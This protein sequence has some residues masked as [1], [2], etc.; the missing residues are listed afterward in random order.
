MILFHLKTHA[1]DCN[2]VAKVRYGAPT[3]I[4]FC[5]YSQFYQ[6]ITAVNLLVG[7]SAVFSSLTGVNRDALCFLFP[8]GVVIYTLMGGIKA[9]FITDWV[10]LS[11][12][13]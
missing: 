11:T 8:I 3:H 6:I 12:Q 10:F 4:L 7:G 2:Q 13:G 9:T 5:C 1:A